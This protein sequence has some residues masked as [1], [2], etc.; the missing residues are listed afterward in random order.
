MDIRID[1]IG[2]SVVEALHA[3]GYMDSTIRV[4]RK[5]FRYLKEASGDGLYTEEQGRRWVGAIEA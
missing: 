2:E 3:A 4:Y 5:Y 1:S